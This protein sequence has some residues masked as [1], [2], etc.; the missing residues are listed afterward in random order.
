MINSLSTNCRK[1]TFILIST[2]TS[3]TLRLLKLF[4]LQRSFIISLSILSHQQL[5]LSFLLKHHLY[6]E[7]GTS[8]K[9]IS[10]AIV[11]VIVLLAGLHI[12]LERG[13]CTLF[14]ILIEIFLVFVTSFDVYVFFANRLKVWSSDDVVLFIF[15]FVLLFRHSQCWKQI[16][17]LAIF[18]SLP[19]QL[20]SKSVFFKRFLRYLVNILPFIRVMLSWDVDTKLIHWLILF[21]ISLPS[22]KP[23][24]RSRLFHAWC[25]IWT[26]AFVLSDSIFLFHSELFEFINATSSIFPEDGFHIQFFLPWFTIENVNILS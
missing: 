5:W 16:I 13:L 4:I 17:K 12:H 1:R 18:P 14:A 3:N 7:P 11:L 21:E 22:S 25:G 23:C 20:T 19:I 15:L 9:L 26:S 2:T 24:F 6:L 8:L 10:W